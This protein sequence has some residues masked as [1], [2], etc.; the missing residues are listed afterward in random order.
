MGRVG[1]FRRENG[2]GLLQAAP[3]VSQCL[4]VSP[5]GQLFLYQ[6]PVLA[7][8]MWPRPQMEEMQ[9]S[10]WELVC[11][12]SE[13]HPSCLILYWILPFSLVIY[14]LRQQAGCCFCGIQ[15]LPLWKAVPVVLLLQLSVPLGL[16]R[17]FGHCLS[18]PTAPPTAGILHLVL[19]KYQQEKMRP[20]L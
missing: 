8:L 1:E 7:C 19:A 17:E 2:A 3:S 15:T 16:V 14:W 9:F 10:L 13:H 11:W 6:P 18:I 4:P 5:V 12:I 20:K